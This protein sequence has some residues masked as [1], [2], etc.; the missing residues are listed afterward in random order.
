MAA[1]LRAGKH[2]LA[3]AA[4]RRVGP[5]RQRLV[6]PLRERVHGRLVHLGGALQRQPPTLVLAHGLAAAARRR[7][8]NAEGK[9]E[10]QQGNEQHVE[11]RHGLIS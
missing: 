5:G 4:A 2:H 10:Q 1:V 3:P 11:V 9:A 7:R 8:G 6:Q